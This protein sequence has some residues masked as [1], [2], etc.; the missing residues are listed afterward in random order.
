MRPEISSSQLLDA[1]LD[2]RGS[3][4]RFSLPRSG[5]DGADGAKSH[6]NVPQPHITCTT[7]VGI[8]KS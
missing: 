4:L 2:A 1:P 5:A 7:I 3:R 6:F 8:P